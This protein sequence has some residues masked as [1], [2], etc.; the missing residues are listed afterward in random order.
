METT[1]KQAQIDLDLNGRQIKHHLAAADRHERGVTDHRRSAGMLLIACRDAVAPDYMPLARTPKELAVSAV[2]HEW[3]ALYDI[4]VMTARR[5]IYENENPEALARRR[6]KQAERNAQAARDVAEMKRNREA[7]RTSARCS[8]LDSVEK[9][10]A[11]PKRDQSRQPISMPRARIVSS[12]T[13]EQ[14]ARVENLIKSFT[15]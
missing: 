3:L 4:S 2:W 13:D 1:N 7:A 10:E 15:L 11:P 5:H 14:W 12:L 8:T 6:E 9:N